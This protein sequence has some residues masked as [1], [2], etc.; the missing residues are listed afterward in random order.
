MPEQLSFAGFEASP[1]PTESVFVA[2]LPDEEASVRIAQIA[3]RVRDKHKLTGRPLAVWRFHVSLHYVASHVSA[4]VVVE[5][6][7]V[8]STIEMPPFRVAFDRVKSLRGN[9]RDRPLV[10][11]GGDGLVGLVQFQHKLGPAMERAGLGRW[12][13]PS[14]LPHLTLLYGSREVEE[15]A[16]EPVSWTVR[17]FALVHSLLGRNRY[18]PL[19]RWPLRG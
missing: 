11:A 12:I 1:L 5:A 9:R 13:G 19:A 15:Q 18:I 16:I 2:I 17:E 7:D 6:S 8:V 4:N 3:R 14:W 10:L